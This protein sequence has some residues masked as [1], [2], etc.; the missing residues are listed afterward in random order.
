MIVEPLLTRSG[1]CRY[2]S[3]VRFFA[4]RV[5]DHEE[6]LLFINYRTADTKTAASALARALKQEF[7]PGQIFIDYRGIEGGEPW[8]A[9]L[10]QRVEQAT[11]LFALIGKDWLRSVDPKTCER[12]LDQKDD[13]VRVEI[14]C[15][16][17]NGRKVVPILIDGAPGLEQDDLPASI[18]PIA[19]LQTCPLRTTVAFRAD[20]KRLVSLLQSEGFQRQA[21]PWRVSP[22]SVYNR[23]ELHRFVGRDWLS[24]RLNKFLNTH[25]NGYFVV[26][27]QSGMGKTTF[28]AHLVETWGYIHHFVELQPG[29]AGVVPGLRNLAAQIVRAFGLEHEW[30]DDLL[31]GIGEREIPG[32]QIRGSTCGL[33]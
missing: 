28:L 23:V 2:V 18:Q 30:V 20:I 24:E 6:P 16:I 7:E 21:H 25:T 13:W 4:Q 14:E 33:G 11:V 3:I 9:H 10:R 31:S 8:K 32:G 1:N 15:A 17:K 12:R 26:E 27:A 19:S 22:D 29:A 5:M